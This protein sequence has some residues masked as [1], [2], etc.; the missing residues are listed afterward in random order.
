MVDL[1][2]YNIK[3][4]LVKRLVSG[5]VEAGD[6]AIIWNGRDRRDASSASG[7]YFARLVSGKVTMTQRLVLL[8]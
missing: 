1:A 6:H 7:V 3:G 8:Q 5:Q 4:E 2:I